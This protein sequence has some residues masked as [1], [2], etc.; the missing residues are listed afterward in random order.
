MRGGRALACQVIH[1]GDLSPIVELRSERSTAYPS[2]GGYMSWSYPGWRGCLLHL[3]ACQLVPG[4]WRFDTRHPLSE[5]DGA[6]TIAVMS[7]CLRMWKKTLL[8]LW[9]HPSLS[10]PHSW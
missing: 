7:R 3:M 6:L 2:D 10:S 8:F 5:A 1:G 9:A 4:S